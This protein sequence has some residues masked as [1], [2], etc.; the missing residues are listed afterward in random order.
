MDIKLFSEILEWRGD[1]FNLELFDCDDFSKLKRVKQVYGF[2]FNNKGKILII[3]LPGKKEWCLPG[4]GPEK[5]DADWK[6]S[7]KREVIEE[8]DVEIKEIKPFMFIISKCLS[9]ND[10][11][12]KEGIMLRAIAKVKNIL[13]QTI[14][15][16]TEAINERKFV[17]PKEFLKYCP[18]GKNGEIQLKGALE[19]MKELE[20]D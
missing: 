4:G 6:E 17:S 5:F 2:V 10:S 8:A 19:I 20:G 1:R 18:W 12:A 11:G 16:C 7:L 9:K 15:P 13:P 3:R 14:D